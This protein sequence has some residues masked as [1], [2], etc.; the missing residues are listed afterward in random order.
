MLY[1]NFNCFAI[2]LNY[3]L[4]DCLTGTCTSFDITTCSKSVR[5]PGTLWICEK[6]KLKNFA[7]IFVE[8]IFGFMPIKPMSFSKRSVFLLHVYSSCSRAQ[9]KRLFT[10]AIFKSINLDSNRKTWEAEHKIFSEIL[11]FCLRI[12]SR[13]MIE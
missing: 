4:P 1:V 13:E 11:A 12:I 3:Y 5:N 8:V 7:W 10:M 2:K 9:S 6:K